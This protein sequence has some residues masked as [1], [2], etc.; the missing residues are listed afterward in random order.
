LSS[1]SKRIIF[2]SFEVSFQITNA[3]FA[4]FTAA[5]VS[6]LEPRE[7]VA[8]AYSLEGL[9]TFKSFGLAGLTHLPFI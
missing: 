4:A 7:I 6:S 2:S 9:I 3:F 1:F 5:S 8:K